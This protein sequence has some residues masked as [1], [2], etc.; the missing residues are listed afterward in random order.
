MGVLQ[1]NS[2]ET[3]V[4]A[5]SARGAINEPTPEGSLAANS[6]HEAGDAIIMLNADQCITWCNRTAERL[7]D[8]LLPAVR[9]RRLGEVISCSIPTQPDRP[10]RPDRP[11]TPTSPSREAPRLVGG[12]GMLV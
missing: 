6:L 12:R 4:V 7:F 2:R 11:D 3:G 10:D 8:T 1:G 9:G 5:L